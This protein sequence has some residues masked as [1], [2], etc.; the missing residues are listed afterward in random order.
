MQASAIVVAGGSGARMGF[1]V[2]KPFIDVC[3]IPMLLFSLEAFQRCEAVSEIVLVLF[4][5][6][7]QRLRSLAKMPAARMER[8]SKLTRTV[9]GGPRRQDSVFNGLLACS[10]KADI[11]VVHDAARPVLPVEWIASGIEALGDCAGA[12]YATLVTN[13]LKRVGPDRIV[14][15]TIPRE[16]LYEVQ[17]PQIFGKD[18]L[19]RAHEHARAE[20]LAA[21]D[22]AELV[23]AIGGKIRILPGHP[24]NLKITFE[25][26]L[27]VA[28]A[29]LGKR[30]REWFVSE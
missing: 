22:D 24:W 21:T 4:K 28:N 19:V 2:E 3:G 20:D 14:R 12:V 15:E 18:W 26:D 9:Q 13:T 5:G 29:L 7:E 16:E 23:E 17:T 6:G 1:S 30:S 25:D 10:E 27:V 8:F 11:I